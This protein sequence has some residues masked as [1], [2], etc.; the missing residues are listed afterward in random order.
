[1][2]LP[3]TLFQLANESNNRIECSMHKAGTVRRLHALYTH[4]YWLLAAQ[5]SCTTLA[6]QTCPLGCPS[7]AQRRC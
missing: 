2:A 5:S 4:D 7:N 1:M 6:P 3:C